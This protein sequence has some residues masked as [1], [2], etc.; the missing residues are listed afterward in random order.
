MRLATWNVNSLR[1][2]WDRVE[3]WLKA[4]RPDVLCM[5]ETK[6]MQGAKLE[7]G[8]LLSNKFKELGYQWANHGR[9]QWNGTA[10]CSRVGLDDVVEGF[11]D[12]AAA[13]PEARVIWATCGGV[14]VAS[15]YVPNGRVFGFDH[16]HRKLDWLRRLRSYLD[17]FCDPSERLIVAGDFNVAPAD[18]DVWDVGEFVRMQYEGIPDK[19]GADIDVWEVGEFPLATHVSEPER[20]AWQAVCDWGLQDV[21]RLRYPDV[22]G[23]Y[24]FW[25]YQAGRFH[26]REGMRIDHILATSS[27]AETA[28]GVIVDRNARKGHKPSDHAPLVVDL[29]A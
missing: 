17:S 23:L 26:K 21:F 29:V 22:E 14:R 13:D 25:D 6:C 7:K 1:A 9:G 5:Q 28:V 18:I 15:V 10:I 2:R 4:V 19:N 20:L 27:L 11:D 16:Y 3:P 8:G 24:T 12:G